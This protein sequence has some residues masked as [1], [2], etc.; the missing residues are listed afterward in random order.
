MADND[1]SVDWL[2]RRRLLQASAATGAAALAGCSSGGGSEGSSDGTTKQTTQKTQKITLS[3][4][5]SNNEEKALVSD[6]VKQFES[7]HERINVDYS[8]VESK[9]KQKLKTQLGA[10]NAPDAF[11]VDA[12]YF[13]SF[14][15]S[16]VL[17]SLDSIEQ[18]ED[19]DTDDFFQPLLNA[20]KHDGTL[21]GIPKDFSTLGLYVNTSLFEKAGAT[22]EPETWSEFR[23]ALQQVKEQTSVKAPLIEYPSA[24]MWKGLL[25]QNGGQVLS[26][27]GSEVVFAS[28][29]GVE[30]LQ[31][32]V[33]LKKD[34]LLA[35]P[36]QLGASWHGAAIGKQ[37]VASAVIGPWA[38]PFL[39]KNY[40]EVDKV[41]DVAHLPIPEGGQKATAAYTVSYSAS[42]NTNAPGATKSLIKTLTS[43]E[44][45]ADWA[46]KGLALS[47]RKSHQDLEYYQN[48]PRRKTLL[49]AGEWSHPVAY[50][51][52]SEAI[53]NRLHPQLEG[54]MLGKKTPR[55]ALEGAQEGI[56][57]NVL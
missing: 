9:Y 52:K 7:N 8:P 33:D 13:G 2:T 15:S 11:Y 39:K 54:A 18:S 50:G 12:K 49:E 5:T 56:N 30:A 32:L 31:Y 19:F 21:Y 57:N 48:H 36:S 46:R 44:G 53:I 43:K 45:M 3:G 38:L 14:A 51:P 23:T 25:F 35:L 17:L 40:P 26:D 6:L 55:E 29:A 20:F 10:G 37:E 34:G 42:A 41:V 1:T 4:W 47:A 16:G 27:D 24:R 22:T 28:D